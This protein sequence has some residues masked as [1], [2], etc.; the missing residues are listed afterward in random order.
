[1][2]KQSV[3]SPR[4]AATL[5]HASQQ[6]S[7]KSRM[8]PLSFRF[9]IYMD[10]CFLFHCPHTADRQIIP[11][12]K[13]AAASEHP[14]RSQAGGNKPANIRVD[15]SAERKSDPGSDAVE[16]SILR[17]LSALPLSPGE[18]PVL[19][20]MDDTLTVV[21]ERL[22]Y[23][24]VLF[25]VNALLLEQPV[26]LVASPGHEEAL[27]F[28]AT[29]LLRLLR[30]LQWQHI[31]IPLVHCS[32]RA[33]LRAVVNAKVPFLMGGYHDI[34]DS[35]MANAHAPGLA[36]DRDIIAFGD[37][38]AR[39]TLFKTIS[40][41]ALAHVTIVDLDA[42][43]IIPGAG[44]KYAAATTMSS[45]PVPDIDRGIV[46]YILEQ[47]HANRAKE[48]GQ[49]SLPP[50]PP[51]YRLA[52]HQRMDVASAALLPADLQDRDKGKRRISHNSVASTQSVGFFGAQ[53]VAEAFRGGLFTVMTSLFKGL[54]LFVYDPTTVPA[55]REQRRRALSERRASDTSRRGFW[56]RLLNR[57]NNTLS[58]QPSS[59]QVEERAPMSRPIPESEAP[60]FVTESLM[61]DCHG[62]I[63]FLKD[64]VRPFMRCLV[65]TA[66]FKVT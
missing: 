62:F 7:A 61:F 15:T 25:L 30:P 19:S 6:S 53:C 64:D 43:I 40:Y 22:G 8:Y 65:H 47:Q 54:R 59:R 16:Q 60:F 33:M 14:P 20:P 35:L 52:L 18:E 13:Y 50:I 21:V 49:V 24:Y 42:G 57:S 17:A 63:Q 23:K 32:M 31:Y 41:Q 48:Q 51:R 3:G 5:N 38:R 45:A 56:G 29:A 10:G 66:A 58:T 36:A 1:M 11:L 46:D 39:S 26:L 37:A 28:C 27:L 2:E 9:C 55:Q 12:A 4:Q 44:L 34:L